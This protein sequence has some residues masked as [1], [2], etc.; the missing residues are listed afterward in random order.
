MTLNEAFELTSAIDSF[1]YDKNRDLSG[2]EDGTENPGGQD[3]VDAA[4]LQNSIDGLD[5]SS[6]VAV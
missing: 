4:I 3:A 2:Y 5:G 6:F 1:Q